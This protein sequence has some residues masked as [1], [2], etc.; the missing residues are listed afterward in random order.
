MAADLACLQTMQSAGLEKLVEYN[1]KKQEE[2]HLQELKASLSESIIADPPLPVDESIRIAH[3]SK[4]EWQLPDAEIVKVPPCCASPAADC[5]LLSLTLCHLG[6]HVQTDFNPPRLFT[7][8]KARKLP[9]TLA[10]SHL[11]NIVFRDH[12]SH[13]SC[14]SD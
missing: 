8:V 14:S 4:K 7:S 3:D 2:V 6:T 12:Q 1:R 10:P 9:G 5:A 11:G 13:R